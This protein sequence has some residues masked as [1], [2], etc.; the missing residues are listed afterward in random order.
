MEWIGAI[1][2]FMLFY[3]DT[4][5]MGNYS[6]VPDAA[7][8]DPFLGSDTFV[9]VCG[10]VIVLFAIVIVLYFLLRGKKTY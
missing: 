7:R 4:T 1:L 3:D 5:M 6:F 2:L 10:G 8:L 9:L